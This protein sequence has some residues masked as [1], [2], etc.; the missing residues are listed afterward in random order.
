MLIDKNRNNL[1]ICYWLKLFEKELIC[2]LKNKEIKCKMD[3]VI[4]NIYV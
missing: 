3:V 2:F 1:C 4:K